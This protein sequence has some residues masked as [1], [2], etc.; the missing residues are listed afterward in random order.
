MQG[1]LPV[2]LFYNKK[3]FKEVGV[4]PPTTYSELLDLVDTFKNKEGITPIVLPRCPGVDRAD[5]AGVPPRTAS[6]VPKCS[7]PSP[8]ARKAPGRTPAIIKAST[9]CCQD[10]VER[11]RLR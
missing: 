5:V 2:V 8:K 10:L 6:A 11:W 1:V 3:V 7:R 4:E 9:K